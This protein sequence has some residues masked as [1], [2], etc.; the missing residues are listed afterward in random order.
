MATV[1]SLSVTC[2]THSEA[3]KL[4]GSLFKDA[5]TLSIASAAQS[6]ILEFLT[7]TTCETC[8]LIVKLIYCKFGKVILQ[9]HKLT[10]GLAFIITE[11]S[12]NCWHGKS[13]LAGL[14]LNH[15][16]S[17]GLRPQ[18]KPLGKG[19]NGCW[20]WRTHLDQGI[21]ITRTKSPY[22]YAMTAC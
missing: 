19:A 17:L 22:R 21:S 10:I 2:S 9:T 14:L 18:T 4:S 7:S 6:D 16:L 13:R 12:R 11:K 20:S 1:F 5:T 3:T 15:L 8:N